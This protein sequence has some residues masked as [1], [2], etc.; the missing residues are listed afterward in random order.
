[1]PPRF[2][3]VAEIGSP[4]G[5]RGEVGIRV[6]TDFPER[7]SPPAA[8]LLSPPIEGVPELVLDGVRG[9]G[10]LYAHF[11][12]FDTPE[13]ARAL[14]GRKLVIT[15]EQAA[16]L[17]EGS[18]WID[19]LVS[20]AVFTEDGARLGKIEEVVQTTAND[21]YVIRLADGRLLP[22]PAIKEVVLDVDVS[23]GRMVVYL[24]PGLEDLAT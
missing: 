15:G 6:T 1:M 11:R 8:Y 14:T 21:V 3:A 10:R 2:F 18:Y 19:D 7:L 4:H 9:E 12:G 17:E 22:I 13:A 20:M 5:L 16:I 24:V 23:A